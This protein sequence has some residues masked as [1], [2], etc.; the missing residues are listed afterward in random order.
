MPYNNIENKNIMHLDN[1]FRQGAGIEEI[2][3]YVDS[4]VFEKLEENDKQLLKDIRMRYLKRRLKIY[5]KEID[6]NG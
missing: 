5:E 2:V 1:L 3:D 6:I 4:I